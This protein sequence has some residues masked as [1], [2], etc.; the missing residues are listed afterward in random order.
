MTLNIHTM[1]CVL[2]CRLYRNPRTHAHAHTCNHEVLMSCFNNFP[3]RIL[4]LLDTF[5]WLMGDVFGVSLV[6]RKK[7]D[8][9]TV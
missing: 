1:I 3:A 4:A 9:M 6:L 7:N 2:S 5:A 8:A